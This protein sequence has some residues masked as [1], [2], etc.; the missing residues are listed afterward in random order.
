MDQPAPATRT[1]FLTR[2]R[3][4]GLVC[5][6]TLVG[7]IAISALFIPRGERNRETQCT[8][9]LKQI[10]LGLITYC[11]QYGCFP[12]SGGPAGDLP[13]DKRLSLQARVLPFMFCLHCWGLN[14]FTHVD[15][16]Q[17]WDAEPQRGLAVVPLAPILCPS[18]PYVP[19]HGMH[20]GE[21]YLD[22]S[23]L[24]DL[25][26]ATYIGIAGLGKDAGFLKKRDPNAGVLGYDRVTTFEDI[27]DG[28]AFTMMVAETSSLQTPWTSGGEA[29]M[30]GLDT[31]RLPYIGRGR[32]F[33]G[34]H[35][36]AALILLADGSVKKIR[37]SIDR[38]AFEALATIAG[39]EALPPN[40]DGPAR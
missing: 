23:Q 14:D 30:R 7:P 26:P 28:L 40:W 16:S 8:N 9:N 24:K 35:P 27:R 4:V 18:S 38:K 20:S 2:W 25:V 6:A 32:Q 22:R 21:H 31:T 1:R 17:P 12:Y 13:P 10:G 29:T 5:L 34:N 33:G 11:S 36:D 37:A 3:V 19:P 39:G 15:M